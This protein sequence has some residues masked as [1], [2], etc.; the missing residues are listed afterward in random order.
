MG[1]IGMEGGLVLSRQNCEVGEK[2]MSK[3]FEIGR[4][5]SRKTISDKLD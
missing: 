3:P 5:C 4:T 2:A 1:L